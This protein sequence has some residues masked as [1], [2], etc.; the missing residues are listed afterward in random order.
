M[1]KKT[2]YLNLFFVI[3]VIV[4]FSGCK[5][6]N[7]TI[8]GNW[9]FSNYTASVKIYNP[10]A[11]DSTYGIYSYNPQTHSIDFISYETISHPVVDTEVISLKYSNWNIQNNGTYSITESTS[12]NTATTSGAWEYLSNSNPDN[13]V[14]FTN[15]GS[16]FFQLINVNNILSIQSITANKLVLGFNTS[17]SDSLGASSIRTSTITFTK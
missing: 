13:A 3:V 11:G 7:P 10:T 4:L 8:V 14:T 12:N 15:G 17:V 9:Q 5:K 1:T 6:N 2:I 16:I